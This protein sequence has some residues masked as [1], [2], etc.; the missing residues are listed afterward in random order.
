MMHEFTGTESPADILSLLLESLSSGGIVPT[1][2]ENAKIIYEGVIPI[3]RFEAQVKDD[4]G[5]FVCFYRL[6]KMTAN[7]FSECESIFDQAAEAGLF[8]KI[9]SLERD[10]TVRHLAY[11]AMN[12]MIHRLMLLQMAMFEENF[13]ETMCLTACSLFSIFVDTYQKAGH[14]D[15]AKIAKDSARTLLD[16]TVDTAAKK[17]RELLVKVL[18]GL[19]SMHI[20]TSVGRPLGTT[21]PENVK[22]KEAAE[23]EKKVEETIQNLLK[24]RGKMPTKTAVAKALNIGSLTKEGNNTSLTVFGRKIKRLKIDYDAIVERVKL[25]K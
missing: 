6:D 5:E 17:R 21:K 9:D 18:N 4:L 25:D 11:Y 7:V 19:P 8:G 22:A 13:S 1:L 12:V 2:R 23:F 20:P 16:A 10:K 24:S 14:A 15:V 3:L